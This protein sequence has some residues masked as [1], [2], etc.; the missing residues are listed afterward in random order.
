MLITA[1]GAGIAGSLAE[2][3]ANAQETG[4]PAPLLFNVLDFGAV[5]DGKTLNSAAFD[6]ALKACA[7][8]GGGTVH[9][10]AGEYLSGPVYLGSNTVLF[11]APGAAIKG[12]PKLEDYPIEPDRISGESRRGGLVTARDATN[13][14]IIGRGTIDGN[15]MPFH[16]DKI[17]GG[18]DWNPKF[19]RQKDEYMS[20]KYGTETGPL[21]HAERPGNVVRFIKCRNVLLQGITVQNSPTWTMLFHTCEDVNIDGLHI[22]SLGSGRRIPNDDG[23]DLRECSNVRVSNCNIETGDDCIA[24]FGSRNL[25]VSN[26]T[27]A[28]RSAGIRVGYAEGETRNCTFQNLTINSHCGL[29]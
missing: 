8:A 23:M 12:S 19:T 10:P 2:G 25:V 9:V 13:V 15:A 17:K 27:L 4:R 14:A 28:A 29:R 7:A 1:G 26:C 3:I 5:P 16:T 22:N 11:L 20:P 18:G 21:D 24:V 6:R